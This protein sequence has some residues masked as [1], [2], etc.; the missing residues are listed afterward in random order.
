MMLLC[1]YFLGF[2]SDES[3]CEGIKS[4]SSATCQTQNFQVLERRKPVL[5][6][7]FVLGGYYLPISLTRGSD[8]RRR[9][10]T[11]PLV[12]YRCQMVPCFAV[13]IFKVHL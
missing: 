8:D 3:W 12:A 10:G 11:S 5:R 9:N 4:P 13:I 1:V 6:H 2:C 7:G